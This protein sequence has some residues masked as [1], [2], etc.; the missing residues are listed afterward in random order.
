MTTVKTPRKP[1]AGAN[2]DKPKTPRY[3]V[4]NLVIEGAWQKTF[5]TGKVGFFGR[6]YDPS[7]GKRYQIIGAVELA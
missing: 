4:S 3:P 1:K 6:A 5:S 7:T 2:G